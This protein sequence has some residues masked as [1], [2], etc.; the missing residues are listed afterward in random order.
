[1]NNEISQVLTI[2]GVINEFYYKCIG[3][4]YSYKCTCF[5]IKNTP[6]LFAIFNINTKQELETL[7]NSNQQLLTARSSVI[8]KIKEMMKKASIVEK[9]L[10][11]GM[12]TFV[13]ALLGVDAVVE[14]LFWCEE[15]TLM[16]FINNGDRNKSK[17]AIMD[18]LSITQEELGQIRKKAEYL[19][20]N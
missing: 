19:Y 20:L 17:S 15:E 18:Y 5:I 16:S 13:Q 1:M 4:R 12:G 14:K 3:P 10:G 9:V 6:E 8:D 2:D 7:L 11:G